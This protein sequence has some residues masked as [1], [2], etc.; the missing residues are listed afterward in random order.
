MKKTINK[1][2]LRR[3]TVRKLV[4]AELRAVAGG[5]DDTCNSKAASTC[6]PVV[7]AAD[8]VAG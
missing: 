4:E 1:L 5:H 2:A 8:T 3:E 6:P 7:A